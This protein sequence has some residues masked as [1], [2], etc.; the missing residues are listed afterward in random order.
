MHHTIVGNIGYPQFKIFP[1]YHGDSTYTS[2]ARKKG[3]RLL[4]QGDAIAFC[5]NDHS[6]ISWLNPDKPL[7]SYWGDYFNISSPSYWK[8]ELNYYRQIFGLRGVGLYIYQKII[9]FWLFFIFIKITPSS[10][11]QSLKRIKK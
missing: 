7:L 3:Y 11:R 4:I 6:K 5:K 10:W 8:A 1:Q 2:R 9:R